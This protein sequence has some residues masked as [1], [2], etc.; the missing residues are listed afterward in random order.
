MAITTCMSLPITALHSLSRRPGPSSQSDM[1]IEDSG[2]ASRVRHT[3]NRGNPDIDKG[4]RV[5]KGC[6]RAR[7]QY[8][9]HRT[10]TRQTVWSN[11]VPKM[12]RSKAQSG[13]CATVLRE[14]RIRTAINWLGESQLTVYAGIVDGRASA[15]SNHGGPKGT[16]V[17]LHALSGTR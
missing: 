9:I 5:L 11:L 7:L 8:R 12:H 4:G 1:E 16:A 14:M 3:D 15:P 6:M 17:R 13:C 10:A 2:P